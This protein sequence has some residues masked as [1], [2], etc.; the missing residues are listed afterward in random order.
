MDTHKSEDFSVYSD[1]A[2]E[3]ALEQANDLRSQ[4]KNIT[5]MKKNAD[6]TEDY[7]TSY[8][9]KNEMKETIFVS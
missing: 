5:M 7:Y 4:G 9:E 6:K 3:K 2:Y 1:G 8:G